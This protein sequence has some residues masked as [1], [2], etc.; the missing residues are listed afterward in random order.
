MK[1]KTQGRNNSCRLTALCSK[2]ATL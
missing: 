2:I 1:D